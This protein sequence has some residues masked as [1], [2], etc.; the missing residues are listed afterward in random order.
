MTA[1][2]GMTSLI[3]RTR[4]LAAVGT[5]DWSLGTVQYWTD[6]QLQEILDFYRTDFF[7]QQLSGIPE[8][9]AG[10]ANDSGT[11]QYKRFEIPYTDLETIDSGTAI[12]LLT[13][14][15][16]GTVSQAFAAD[17]KRG[18]LVFTA[19]QG[20]TAIYLTGRSYDLNEAAADIWDQKAAHY[21]L[22]Y[23]ITT[24]NQSMKRSQIVAQCEKM[25]NKFRSMAQSGVSS[26][27]TERLDTR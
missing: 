13:Y 4:E 27:S 10:D 8:T 19:D 7:R 21:A 20:G 23:D 16:G 17:Y 3:Q 25:A 18:M 2:A 14:S 24:D 26:I 11:V 12:F 6:D 15:N 22:A 5:A 9:V 1:R